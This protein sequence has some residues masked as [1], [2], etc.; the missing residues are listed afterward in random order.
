MCL[1][2]CHFVRTHVMCMFTHACVY[3]YMYEGV[4]FLGHPAALPV[5]GQNNRRCTWSTCTHTRTRTRTRT[6]CFPTTSA[7]SCLKGRQEQTLGTHQHPRS[8]RR[9]R[10]YPAPGRATP[11]IVPC[12]SRAGSKHLSLRFQRW[13]RPRAR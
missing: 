6:R 7:V 8:R 4:G 12:P 5:H 9:G 11:S 10:L 2:A 13:R 1:C 3:A